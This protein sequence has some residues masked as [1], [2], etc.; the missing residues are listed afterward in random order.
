MESVESNYSKVS[1]Y[2]V[3]PENPDS[4]SQIHKKE[5]LWGCE[6]DP[7]ENSSITSSWSPARGSKLMVLWLPQTKNTKKSTARKSCI[8]SIHALMHVLYLKSLR[9]L[10]D[11]AITDG[12]F[13]LVGFPEKTLSI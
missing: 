9:P 7:C 8:Q 11:R 2:S 1:V 13:I 4:L 6:I 10:S 5:N 12:Y 3:S